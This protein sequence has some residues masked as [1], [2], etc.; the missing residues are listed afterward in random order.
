MI[1]T[2]IKRMLDDVSVAYGVRWNAATDTMTAGIIVN[3]KFVAY[4]YQR[5]PVHD[6]CGRRCVRSLAG[7]RQYYLHPDDSAYKFDETASDL[8]GADGQ[9]MSEFHQFHYIRKNDGDNR[10]CLVSR[11]PF[12]LQLADSSYLRSSVHP[13]FYEGGLTSPVWKKYIGAFEGVLYDTS[14]S[15]YVDGTGALLYAAGDKIHSVYGYRPITYI[16]R[17]EFR[18]G[19]SADGDY[20]QM[21]RVGA[22]EALILLFVTKYKSWNSQ[23]KIPGYTEGGAWDFTKVCKTGIT[24]Q[25]G[26]QDGSITWADAPAALRCSYDFSGTPTIVLANSFL[27]VENFFGHVWK[28]LD[29]IN[30]QFIGDPLTDADVYICNDPDAWAD[31][32]A[33]GYDAAGIDLP[34]ASGYISDVHDRFFLPA[35]NS[36]GSG[37]Y[38]TD[39]FYA[40]SAAGWRAPLSG[41]A[42]SYGAAAGAAAVAANFAAA[43][44]TTHIGGR[45]A[46]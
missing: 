45:P 1:I 7:V 33:A 25:L 34:L 14:A 30:V 21:G 44:R 46:A 19:A 18:A 23:V 16:S 9:A 8:T 10:Y 43:T 28:W 6:L 38:L 13:W 32:T 12:Y 2:N 40:S 3:G 5:M 20:H 11:Y 17:P 15:S 36:G 42:L 41:G 24:A 29:G 27:G 35:N 4:D 37:T 22:R 31:D 39:N 26:N